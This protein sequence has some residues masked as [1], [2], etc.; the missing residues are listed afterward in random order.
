MTTPVRSDTKEHLLDAAERLFAERGLAQTSLR[1]ITQ[2]AGA[3]LAA[4]NYHFGSK[5]ALVRA[6]MHRRLAPL[7]EDRLA[8]LSEAE[9]HAEDG[10]A[11]LEAILQAFVLPPFRLLEGGNEPFTRFLGRLHFEADEGVQQL[12][13]DAFRPVIERFAE[14][15]AS[16]LPQLAAEDVLWR[17]HFAVGAMAMAVA[18][19]HLLALYSGGRCDP[20]DV[21]GA[22]ERLVA[23]LAAGFR[24]AAEVRGD[25]AGAGR[26]RG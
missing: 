9:R 25:S 16:T 18:N 24:E 14:A 5:E 2:E 3:N 11:S 19:R 8:L 6:V 17:F 13:V 4:V 1:A 21:E 12:I 22:V 15:L 7:N 26:E 20:N 23:F 10:R